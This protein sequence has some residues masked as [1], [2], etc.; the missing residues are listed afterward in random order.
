MNETGAPRLVAQ[1]PAGGEPRPWRFPEFER[2]TVAGGRL[3]A[4]HLPGKPLA[5]LTLV[6]DAGA[7]AEPPGREGLALLV[8]AALSEGAGDQDAYAFAVAGER[9]GAAW[10]ADVDW[11][12]MRCGFEVPIAGLPAAAE[13][14]AAAVRTP[15]FDPAAV[16]RVTAERLDELLVELSQPGPRAAA[17]FAAE[18]FSGGSRYARPLGGRPDTVAAVTDDD[19]R[20]FHGER[21]G[22]DTATLLAVGD[23]DG[24]DVDALGRTVFEGWASAAAPAADPVVHAAPSR[25]PRVVLVDRPGSVQSMLY[26]GHDGPARSAADYVPLTTMALALGGMFNSR[27]NLRLREDKGYTYGAFGSFDCR[28]HGGVFAARSAVQT[29][30]TGPALAALLAEVRLMHDAG[31]DEEE[32]ARARSYRAGIFPVNF[33]TPAA[34]AH[35]LGELVVHGHPDDHFDRLRAAVQEVDVAAVNAAAAARLRPDDL[36]SVVVGDAGVIAADL[37]AGSAGPVEIVRDAG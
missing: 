19:V 11:D 6:L 37:E 13:L 28:R 1:R 9:L 8:A 7:V 12:S 25:G 3:I 29:E 5:V 27:L 16:A 21:F 33:A 36:V 26:A 18:V 15:A 35:G 17:A 10:H 32:L 31:V 2:R 34:V 23:L 22:P 20:R 14:L 30:V 4:C 24:V